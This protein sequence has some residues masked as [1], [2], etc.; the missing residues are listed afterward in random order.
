MK[1]SYSSNDALAHAWANNSDISVVRSGS[2]FWCQYDRLYSFHTCIAEI[3]K[4][5]TIFNDHSHSSYTARHQSKARGASHGANISIDIP[6]RGHHSIVFSQGDFERIVVSYNEAKAAEHLLKADRARKTG[7][8]HRAQA[9]SRIQSLIDYAKLVGLS[10]ECDEA[11]MEVLKQAAETQR[12]LD[13]AEAKEYRAKRIAKQAEDMVRWRAGENVYVSFEQ[14]ALRIMDGEIQ[15]SH[16]ASIPLNQAVDLWP[17]VRQAHETGKPFL[18]REGRTIH[19]GDFT[20]NCFKDDVLTVGCHRIPYSELA[21]IA[22]QLG[23]LETA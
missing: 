15:T 8:W 21:L 11:G 19:L 10:Y 6:G 13:I 12:L 20:L 3:Y 7:D 14:T 16:G 23:L 9:H 1:K 2:N 5:T 22:E 18:P 4:N 17:F